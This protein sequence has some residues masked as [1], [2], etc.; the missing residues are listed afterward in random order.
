MFVSVFFPSHPVQRKVLI[1]LDAINNIQ[2]YPSWCKVGNEDVSQVSGVNHHVSP[3]TWFNLPQKDHE[4]SPT[5]SFL[6][7][8]LRK[9]KFRRVRST[10][11]KLAPLFSLP[12]VLVTGGRGLYWKDSRFCEERINAGLYHWYCAKTLPQVIT[13]K[14]ACMYH[15]DLHVFVI[16]CNSIY[17]MASEYAANTWYTSHNIISMSALRPAT[18]QAGF[19]RAR[20]QNTSVYSTYTYIFHLHQYM[21]ICFSSCAYCSVSLH[22]NLA[23]T[24]VWWLGCA[25]A[26]LYGEAMQHKCVVIWKNSV[27]WFPSGGSSKG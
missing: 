10:N 17:R 11:E 7:P 12:G 25:V 18:R 3:F 27:S 14:T 1:N 26:F 19:L 9:E 20:C 6:L 22:F 16:F 23:R 15:H 13:P 8:L 5:G 24:R 21:Y 4:I 2:L